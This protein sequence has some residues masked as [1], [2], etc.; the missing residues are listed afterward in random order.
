MVLVL[1]GVENVGAALVEQ[2]GDARDQA[3]PVRAIDKQNGR[4]FH[5]DFRVSH[6]GR[7]AFVFSQAGDFQ[8]GFDL[9]GAH[10]AARA[11]RRAR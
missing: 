6:R 10:I 3:L 2:R 9:A 7:I 1:V 5:Q 4:M 11:G 8:P